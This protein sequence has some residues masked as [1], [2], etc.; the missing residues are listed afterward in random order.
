MNALIGLLGAVCVLFTVIGVVI[1]AFS[2][3]MICN[4]EKSDG[5]KAFPWGLAIIATFFSLSV[6]CCNKETLYE[7]QN[8]TGVWCKN[9]TVVKPKINDNYIV[10]KN[11]SNTFT[12][13]RIYISNKKQEVER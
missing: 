9:V 6:I 11:A 13:Y 12:T 10:I 3:A 7:Y 4:G 5:W 2:I 1:A 8:A